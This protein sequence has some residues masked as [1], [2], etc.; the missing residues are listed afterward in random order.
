MRRV[1]SEITIDLSLLFFDNHTIHYLLPFFMLFFF[2][3]PW[4]PPTFVGARDRSFPLPITPP[5]RQDIC[6][7]M[8]GLFIEFFFLFFS[9]FSFLFL[10]PAQL[11]HLFLF[12]FNL[13]NP[14]SHPPLPLRL[15]FSIVLFIII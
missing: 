1:W 14:L 13:I 10:L 9:F 6:E 4:G 3:T 8:D 15:N 11:I 5:S 12:K 7:L 2:M